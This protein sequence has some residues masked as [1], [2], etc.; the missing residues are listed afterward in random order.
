MSVIGVMAQFKCGG[1][2]N[3]F[4]AIRLEAKAEGKA[5]CLSKVR[6]EIFVGK[7]VGIV[8]HRRLS[9][10]AVALVKPQSVFHFYIMLGKKSESEINDLMKKSMRELL[11]KDVAEEADMIGGFALGALLQ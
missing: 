10:R 4:G 2:L 5:V 1:R 7:Y 9:I 3:A 11:P 6:P 8:H